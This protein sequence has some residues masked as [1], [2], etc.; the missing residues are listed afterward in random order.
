MLPTP[1]HGHSS[2]SP[3][4]L[5]LT[6]TLG[7]STTPSHDTSERH[8]F[9][10]LCRPLAMVTAPCPAVPLALAP[11]R[12]F[13]HPSLPPVRHAAPAATVAKATAAYAPC[14]ASRSR[15]AVALLPP[16][17]PCARCSAVAPRLLPSASSSSCPEP[18]LHLLLLLPPPPPPQPPAAS[19]AGC[20][21][22]RC[23]HPL[24]H[25]RPHARS[26]CCCTSPSPPLP[27]QTV[28]TGRRAAV[29]PFKHPRPRP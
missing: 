20:H 3:P 5:S 19:V 4:C 24:V 27:A 12:R 9:P 29:H 26:S 1:P 8:P 6:E 21:R 13:S 17:S 14:F 7:A 18:P 25:F 16:S 15:P 22:D 11:P 23:Q 2:P 28:A 10:S